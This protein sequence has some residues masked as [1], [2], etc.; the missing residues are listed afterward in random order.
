MSFGSEYLERELKYLYI[1]EDIYCWIGI[2]QQVFQKRFR[3]LVVNYFL[4]YIE[5]FPR[6]GAPS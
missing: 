2:L 6:W 5:N 3:W 1:I 4:K